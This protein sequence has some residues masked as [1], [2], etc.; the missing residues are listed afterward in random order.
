MIL[1][2]K[3]ANAALA[4]QSRLIRKRERANN[5]K[6]QKIRDSA[7]LSA[8]MEGLSGQNV[9]DVVANAIPQEHFRYQSHLQGLRTGKVRN[10][11]RLGYLAYGFLRQRPYAR[12]EDHTK[13]IPDFDEVLDI[14]FRYG[15]TRM[16]QKEPVEP[17]VIAQHFT[18]WLN[19]ATAYLK[20]QDLEVPGPFF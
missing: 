9:T 3:M 18:E 17:Q 8:R 10:A 14:A 1:D 19:A 13:S 16:D 6:L 7:K 12:I 2:L 11:A 15:R 5:R 20:G 4:A